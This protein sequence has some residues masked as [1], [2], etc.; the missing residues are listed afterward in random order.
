MLLGRARHEALHGVHLTADDERDAR[1][2]ALIAGYGAVDK[3]FPISAING[4][5]CRELVFAIMAHIEEHRRD[6][7]QHASAT[8]S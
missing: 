1:I 6:P 3:V 7:G 4:G 8:S 5:G 2:A